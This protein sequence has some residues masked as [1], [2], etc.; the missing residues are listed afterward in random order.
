MKN[1]LF[2]CRSNRNRSVIAEHYFRELLT[3]KK[4]EGVVI[5]AGVTVGSRNP[6]TQEM[7]DQADKV[8][9][10]E[11]ALYEEMSLKLNIDRKKVVNLDI[12]DVYL[13]PRGTFCEHNLGCILD[14]MVDNGK[15]EEVKRIS[16]KDELMQGYNLIDVLKSRNLEQYI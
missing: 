5:S 12:Q 10:M 8:F 1:Y 9:V 7:L 15:H 6:V 2:I 16:Q 3:E 4:K 13:A 11:E 14:Y